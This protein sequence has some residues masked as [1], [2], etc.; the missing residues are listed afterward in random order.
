MDDDRL[1]ARLADLALLTNWL[2]HKWTTCPPLTGYR[3]STSGCERYRRFHFT[4]T[5]E[6]WMKLVERRSL[7]SR[8]ISCSAPPIATSRNG[9]RHPRLGARVDRE[10]AAHACGPKTTEQILERLA[11]YC[12]AINAGAK[13]YRYRSGGVR[14][15]GRE[16]RPVR[17]HAFRVK[18]CLHSGAS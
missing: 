12:A 2:L 15:P 3:P 14:H 7:R 8:S 4:P 13:S 5:Y 10:P 16:G 9:R 17:V 11:G 18:R 1:R 6:S